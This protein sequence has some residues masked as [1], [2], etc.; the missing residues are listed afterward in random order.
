MEFLSKNSEESI[1]PE[2]VIGIDNKGNIFKI[3]DFYGKYR[4]VENWRLKKRSRTKRSP[5]IWF[6]FI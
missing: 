6:F 5:N 3:N 1:F 4:L 2:D